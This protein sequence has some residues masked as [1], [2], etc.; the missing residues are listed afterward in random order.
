MAFFSSE[1]SNWRH[2]IR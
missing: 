1:I 2:V